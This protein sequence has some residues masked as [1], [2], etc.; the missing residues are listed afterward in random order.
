M[1]Y[2]LGH[3]AILLRIFKSNAHMSCNLLEFEGFKPNFG[4]LSSRTYV[5]VATVLSFVV[6]LLSSAFKPHVCTSCN[7]YKINS[8]QQQVSVLSSRTYVRVATAKSN[9]TCS[10]CTDYYVHLNLFECFTSIDIQCLTVT[11]SISGW[12][13]T[14]NAVR[15][16]ALHQLFGIVRF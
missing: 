2:P 8:V 1:P 5:R 4:I 6:L 10:S 14:L 9:K 15:T 11:F 12:E 3:T 16:S 13:S 7:I